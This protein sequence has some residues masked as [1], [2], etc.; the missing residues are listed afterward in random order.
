MAPKLSIIMSCRNH[1]DLVEKSVLSI[2][3]QTFSD[4]EFLIMDD[5]S[6][7]GTYDILLS[8]AKQDKRIKLYKNNS[9][10]GLTKN[11]NSLI[12][13]SSSNIIGRQDADDTSIQIYRSIH[14]I[15]T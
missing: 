4:F 8:L 7:D 5:Y 11:L 15:F 2:L 6:V 14:P 12:N 1:E 10:V 3:N 9:V 13:T